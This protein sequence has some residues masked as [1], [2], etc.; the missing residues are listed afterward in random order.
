[1]ELLHNFPARRFNLGGFAICA[2][3]LGYAYYLQFGGGLDP[4]P[5]CIFQRI[6]MIALGAVF[7]L[8]ALHNPQRTGQRIYGAV[9]A[10]TALA[11]ASVAGR[12]VWLQ[13][14]PPEQVPACG[15]DLEYM[16]EILPLAEVIKRVFTA[17]GECAE[18]VWTFL[19]LSMP[20]WVLIW[21]VAL[22]VAGLIA[23]WTSRVD[24][25]H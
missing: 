2:A 1:M 8:A 23:N 15:P 20:S 5:L 22:G 3:L 19:G 4:C 25:T 21:F 24:R 14:L 9:I 17:S 12:H 6:G 7:L 13:H 16:L 10:L 11:G 18:V